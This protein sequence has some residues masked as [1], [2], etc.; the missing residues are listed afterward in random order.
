[1]RA[2]K[3]L[4][5]TIFLSIISIPAVAQDC[6]CSEPGFGSKFNY[7]LTNKDDVPFM[8]E[9]PWQVVSCSP[10]YDMRRADEPVVSYN[11]IIS[12]VFEDNPLLD[13]YVTDPDENEKIAFR[14]NW[15]RFDQFEKTLKPEDC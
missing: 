3:I 4:V 12:L 15:V 11:I 2:A 6:T 7:E 9:F 10:V 1:M 13:T 14:D 8:E 5:P